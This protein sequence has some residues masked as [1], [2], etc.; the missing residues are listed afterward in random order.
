MNVWIFR[1][2]HPVARASCLAEE[3]IWKSEKSQPAS[4]MS[5]ESG[6]IRTCWVSPESITPLGTEMESSGCLVATVTQSGEETKLAGGQKAENLQL[7][8]TW[9]SKKAWK[10][11]KTNCSEFLGAP[12]QFLMREMT[13]FTSQEVIG[14][15][16]SGTRRSKLTILGMTELSLFHSWFKIFIFKHLHHSK[17]QGVFGCPDEYCKIRARMCWI[18]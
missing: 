12:V 5:M 18:L 13:R 16:W 7:Y 15:I 1:L 14:K 4:T 2:T 9:L 3:W 11:E 17:L 10:L 6:N 8:N